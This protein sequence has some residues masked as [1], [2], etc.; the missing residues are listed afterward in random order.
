MSAL[1]MSEFVGLKSDVLRV[2]NIIA[3]ATTATQPANINAGFSQR[4]RFLLTLLLSFLLS[5]GKVLH[6]YQSLPGIV[7]LS[8]FID[9]M[10]I[11]AFSIVYVKYTL[12]IASLHSKYNTLSLKIHHLFCWAW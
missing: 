8:L 2:T 3:T 1:P 7:L 4:I 9:L 6:R 5:V 10:L 12:F 11:I